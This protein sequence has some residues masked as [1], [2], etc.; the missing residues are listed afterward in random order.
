MTPLPRIKADGVSVVRDGG[1]VL[2]GVSLELTAGDFVTVVG[3]NGA[4]KTT[5]L[6]VL[7]G[8]LAPDAG[9][10]A[11]RPGLALGYIPQRIGI[12]ASL[13]M[14]AERFLRLGRGRSDPAARDAVAGETGIAPLLDRQ[15]Q[16]LSG[17]EWQRVLL[18]RALLGA[19][20]AIIL[21]EPAQN[22]DISGQ[23]D[24]Y[25]LLERVH[26]DRGVA[27][28]MVSHDLHMVMASTRRVV[29]LYHHVCCSG[30]P[31]AVA[32]DPE[33]IRLFGRDMARMM[34]VY[35]H[36]HDHS[37]DHDGHAHNHGHGQGQMKGHGHG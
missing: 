24:F 9:R 16:A 29:C 36:D 17:G 32:R 13:P 1:K 27:I 6:K 20:D 18:A 35:Q 15:V 19:P 12:D 7:A 26:R 4:G 5:L 23:L 34:A 10:V 28:A 31:R 8:L 30:E 21:D 11:R 22:L 25:A 33:F 37:H 14:T 3:P 2:D